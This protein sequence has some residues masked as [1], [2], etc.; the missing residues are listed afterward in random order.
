MP[1]CSQS[2]NPANL[3]QQRLD[4]RYARAAIG[5]GFQA[6]ADFLV[7]F[8]A[9]FADGRAQ[10]FLADVETGADHGAG[11]GRAQ[12]RHALPVYWNEL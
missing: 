10:G 2:A 12:G 5:A 3:Q 7:G 4:L 11:I 1:G 6:A 9:F 8:Q